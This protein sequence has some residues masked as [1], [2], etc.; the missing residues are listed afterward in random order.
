MISQEQIS[1]YHEKGYLLLENYF[2]PKEV[3]L[4]NSQLTLLMQ[5]DGPRKII[6]SNGEIRSYYGA[7]QM[8]NIYNEVA[9]VRKLVEP[10]KQILDSDIYIHQTKVN[11]KKALKG[12]WWEWHQ[13]F[14]YWNLEDGMPLPRV[15][16]VMI[17]LD[18]VTEFNGPLMVI[19]G[20]HK[21]GIVSFEDKQQ[22]EEEVSY[23]GANLK[24][25]IGRS[26]LTKGFEDNNVVS[27]I[28]KAGSVLF[29]HGNI[30]HASNCNMSP[31]DRRTYII[32]Y[33]SVENTLNNVGKER[34]E[35]LSERN[36]SPLQAL[37]NEWYQNAE[38]T[39]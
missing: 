10:V 7:H 39:S 27:T 1:Q 12:N 6:E 20:S 34:P 31:F 16:S 35:F 23:T 17:Y 22:S 33:N 36:F 4:M 38:I 3:S 28:G 8:N 19:P 32:T 5:D 24:Y 11:F 30:F 25:T 9:R 21:L 13:D 14:P 15:T 29:F 37:E 2:T 26:I 18:D